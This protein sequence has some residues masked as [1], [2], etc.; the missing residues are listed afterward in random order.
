MADWHANNRKSSPW[1]TP[2]A[3]TLLLVVHASWVCYTSDPTLSGVH[4]PNDSALYGWLPEA[5]TQTSKASPSCQAPRRPARS[6]RRL[7]S[8]SRTSVLD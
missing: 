3:S 8:S 4:A 5:H 1:T 6:S 7:E 2:Q